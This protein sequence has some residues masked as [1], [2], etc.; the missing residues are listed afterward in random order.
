MALLLPVQQIGGSPAKEGSDVIL[1]A[2]F[3]L[4]QRCASPDAV[5]DAAASAEYFDWKLFLLVLIGRFAPL[6][7]LRVKLV[8]DR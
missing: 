7:E 1:P 5:R 6:E 4:V 8:R 3:Y 2:L